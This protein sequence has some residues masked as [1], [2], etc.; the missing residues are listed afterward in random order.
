[1]AAAAMGAINSACSRSTPASAPAPGADK[2]AAAPR[3]RILILGGT[4]F[5]GPKTVGAAIARGHTLDGILRLQRANLEASV[6]PDEAA[7]D[8]FVTVVHTREILERMH[9]IAP[10]IVA[11]A[12]GE[13]VGYAL[14]MPLECGPL[15]PILEPMFRQFE[16]LE[17]QGRPLLS[18]RVYVMGQRAPIAAAACSM[19]S[20]PDTAH[21]AGRC[22]LLVTEV[23]VSNARSLVAHLRVGFIT[24]GRYTG[25]NEEWEVVAL[26]IGDRA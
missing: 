15:I 26:P 11:R 21:Y 24:V 9:A 10:S 22:D 4:G 1:M 2:P 3:K 23:A 5:L 18:H 6:G 20:T 19:R 25:G 13:V 7:R 14:A 17:H 12:G 16:A 8:G